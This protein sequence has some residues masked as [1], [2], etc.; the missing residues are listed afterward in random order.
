MEDVRQGSRPV[1]SVRGVAAQD[2]SRA[3]VTAFQQVLQA[4][5]SMTFHIGVPQRTSASFA[6]SGKTAGAGCRPNRYFAFTLD[7]MEV[8]TLDAILN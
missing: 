5:L 6:G 1:T 4:E 8:I 2:Q 3:F 7:V